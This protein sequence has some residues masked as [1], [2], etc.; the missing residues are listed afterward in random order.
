MAQDVAAWLD[1]EGIK[2]DGILGHSFGGKVALAMADLWRARPLQVWIIDSTPDTRAPSG[3]AWDLLRT[4]RDLP[5]TFPS[6]DALMA[7]LTEHHWAPA[8]AQWMATNL[9]R[10]GDVF[11]W[12][13]NLD[14]MDELLRDF[15]AAD[16]WSV[17]ESPA[18]DH[19]LH[20]IK[21]TESGVMTE[22][23]V[24]RV[25][26]TTS[27]RVHVH[28][29]AGGHWI[30]A[31]RPDDVVAALARVLPRLAPGDGAGQKE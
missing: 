9:V 1:A 19:S 21:A 31:E 17:V 20:F 28:R 25:E 18:P 26:A 3:S 8:V 4:I 7:A 15:F 5:P 22:E 14:V 24:R 29:L 16:L 6:R 27:G 23:A 11:T 2:P 12:R 13:L 10:Q 30:H